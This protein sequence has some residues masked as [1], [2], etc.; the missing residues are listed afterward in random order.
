MATI[1]RL[2]KNL[3][4]TFVPFRGCQQSVISYQALG[5]QQRGSA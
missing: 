4:M 5:N 2:M 1:G 3:D